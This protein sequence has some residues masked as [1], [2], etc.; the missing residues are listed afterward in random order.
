M[1]AR[2]PIRT[3]VGCRR[4]EAAAELLRVVVAPDALT[5]D[6]DSPPRVIVPDPR[7]RA[8]GRGAWVHPVPGCLE[9]AERRRAFARTLRVSGAVDL[10]AV[11]AFVEQVGDPTRGSPQE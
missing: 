4:R 10:A 9:L 5:L 2:V 1:P 11:H 8:A 7:H 6:G 3:C